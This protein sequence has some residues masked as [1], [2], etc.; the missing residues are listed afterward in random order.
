MRIRIALVSVAL[1]LF[2]A[3]YAA[4]QQNMNQSYDPVLGELADSEDPQAFAEQRGLSYDN[5]TV[6]AVIELEPGSDTPEGYSVEVVQE[7][8][9]SNESLVEARMPVEDVRSIASEEGVS[10]VRAPS[11]PSSMDTD[12]DTDENNTTQTDNETKTRESSE[13]SDGFTSV[14]AVV[15]LLTAGYY[16]RWSHE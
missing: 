4:A 1:F 5:G 16:V 10:Y 11:T 8:E 12:P 15:A 13:E 9:G 14:L 7:Y 3:G 2:V 6:V